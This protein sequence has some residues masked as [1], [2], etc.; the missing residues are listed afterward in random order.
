MFEV[1]AI[2]NPLVVDNRH[3]GASPSLSRLGKAPFQAYITKD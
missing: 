2:M 3:Q 1:G